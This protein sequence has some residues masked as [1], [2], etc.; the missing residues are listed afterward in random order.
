MNFLK[1]FKKQIHKELKKQEKEFSTYGLNKEAYNILLFAL[2]DDK[3]LL[4]SWLRKRAM[5][6]R[7]FE[8][9]EPLSIYGGD[10]YTGEKEL[11]ITENDL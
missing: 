4:E 2:N 10:Y 5:L 3:E 11:K 8:E 9:K 1:R 6:S 7:T